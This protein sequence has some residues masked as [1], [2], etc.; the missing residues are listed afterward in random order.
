M[1]ENGLGFLVM[2][3]LSWLG[4]EEEDPRVPV[5]G[6]KGHS[7]SQESLEGGHVREDLGGAVS[8]TRLE[9][10]RER[11]AGGVTLGAAEVPWAGGKNRALGTQP[12]AVRGAQLAGKSDWPS[13]QQGENTGDDCPGM[14]D[15]NT[16]RSEGPVCCAG[17]KQGSGPAPQ[18]E[19]RQR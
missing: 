14:R 1:R 10:S 6:L 18:L 4:W 3:W 8:W 19:G 5:S 9:H 2:S 7:L 15:R 17:R 16:W 13:R 11:R 12:R